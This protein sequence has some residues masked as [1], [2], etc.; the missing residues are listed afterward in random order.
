METNGPNTTDWKHIAQLVVIGVS[1]AMI[2]LILPLVIG[3]LSSKLALTEGQTSLIAF[4]DMVG[5]AVSSLAISRFIV[6]MS[7]RTILLCA[8]G[9]MIAGN[10]G[11]LYATDVNT[12]CVLRLL[13]GL[14]AGLGLS[15]AN[16]GLALTPNP[17]RA[18]GIYVVVALL[19]GAVMLQILTPIGIEA[20]LM[21]LAGL[22]VLVALIAFVMKRAESI[23]DSENE[24]QSEVSH[25]VVPKLF[26]L[27]AAGGIL[28][29][30]MGTG[31]VW[32]YMERLGVSL[33]LDAATIGSNL[34]AASIAGGVGGV[35]AIMLSTRFGRLVPLVISLLVTTAAMFA[36]YSKL[37]PSTF[38]FGA[39][40]ILAG[41]NF[42]YPYMI[43]ALVS[44]DATGRF[45]PVAASMQ[46]F[47][48]AFGPVTAS[49]LFGDQVFTQSTSMG[50]VLHIVALVLLVPLLLKIKRHL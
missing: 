19:V 22:A 36:L 43:G 16:A 20:V 37:S 42:S 35:C 25:P 6:S 45:V 1:S 38:L 34:G 18:I 40:L 14:G 26:M 50:A 46:L 5:A 32:A 13:A 2:L 47:G 39:I 11:S 21:V 24:E 44:A 28:A 33:S 4:F 49:R 3:G 30:F 29:Y 7:W 8:A 12:L 23:S 27:A 10:V 31:T 9:L 48:F 41:W 15:V 17:D